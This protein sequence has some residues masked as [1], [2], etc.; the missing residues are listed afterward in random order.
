ME[1]TNK[2]THGAG[3]HMKKKKFGRR[4]INYGRKKRKHNGYS[5]LSHCRDFP[6]NRT[7]YLMERQQLKTAKLTD[8]MP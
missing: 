5:G 2:K 6:N 8:Y 4:T 1:Y 7:K 3:K